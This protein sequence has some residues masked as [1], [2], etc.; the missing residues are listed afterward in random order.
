[1]KSLNAMG[2]TNYF[3]KNSL[4]Y[5]FIGWLFLANTFLFWI[6]GFN[7]LNAILHSPTLFPNSFGEYF[8]TTR[9]LIVFFALANYFSYM[10]LLAFIPALFLIFVTLII[11]RRR[12]IIILSVLIASISALFLLVDSGVYAMFK[13]HLNQNIISLVFSHQWRK[14][15]DFS[16]YEI[17]IMVSI[18]IFIFILECGIAYLILVKEALLSR[19]KIGKT[20]AS[21]WLAGALFSYFCLML[22]IVKN[23]N[24]FSQQ[25]PNLPIF[26]QLMAY[27]TPNKDL[28]AVLLQ[29]SGSHFSQPILTNKPLYYPQH[30]LRCNPPSKPYNIILIM[31]DALRFNSMQKAYMPN[32]TKFAAESW[33]FQKHFSGGNATQPGLVSLFYS[34]PGSYWVSIL[35]QKRTPVFMDL[36]LKWRYSA[37]VIWSAEMNVPPFDK[38]IYGGL[39]NLEVDGGHGQDVGNWDRHTTEQA[40]QFLKEAN[41]QKPFFLNLFYEAGHGYCRD[42]SF[43]TVYKPIQQRCSRMAMMN[44]MQSDLDPLPYYNR[45]LNAVT[46]IDSEIEKVLDTINE[47]GYLKD[48]IIII[49][50]DHGQEFNDNHQNYWGHASNYTAAQTHVPLIIHWP[51]EPPR[52]IDY[53]TSSYD[54]VPTLLERMFSCNNPI[55]DYSVGQNL[56]NEHDRL[57]FVLSGSYVGMGIIEPDR[58]TALDASGMVRIMNTNA[59]P[60]PNVQPHIE[61]LNKALALMNRYYSPPNNN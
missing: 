4:I 57:P 51:H 16:Q 60:T 41:H 31:V 1:M 3:K 35:E 18:I 52:Q 25:T 28:Q 10:M 32:I 7:Y 45:Y 58:L 6:L 13:F 29:Y 36:L 55:S 33:Q 61:Q 14:V 37:R 5:R 47:K 19:F 21:F 49:T 56:L 9:C 40:I 12:F 24:I 22:T 17:I 26:N 30:T 11:P 46:F 8:Y 38:T 20:I 44:V 2:L 48:S 15:F 27:L 42:Q 43:P 54:I 59:K 39:K 53:V 23:D 50:S 34:I